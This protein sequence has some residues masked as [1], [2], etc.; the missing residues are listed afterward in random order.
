MPVD[1]ELRESDETPR[2]LKKEKEDKRQ[3]YNKVE[4]TISVGDKHR[5][6]V[7]NARILCTC[8]S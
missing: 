5:L 8:M 7:L 2:I 3:S 1:R 4:Y 6:Y